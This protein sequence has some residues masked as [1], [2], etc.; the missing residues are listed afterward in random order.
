[1]STENTIGLR[2][3]ASAFRLSP[4]RD[5]HN[6][7]FDTV[8]VFIPS[9]LMHGGNIGIFGGAPVVLKGYRAQLVNGLTS[10]IRDNDALVVGRMVELHLEELGRLDTVT[11]R[12]GGWHRFLAEV[13]GPSSGT[14][15]SAWVYQQLGH[16]G[17]DELETSAD[18]LTEPTT[19]HRSLVNA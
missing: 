10:I 4:N 18:A 11:E 5:D 2:R 9:P 15:F 13:I 17:E 6:P 12:A 1:M 19:R 3:A 7:G 16:A 8:R 14:A